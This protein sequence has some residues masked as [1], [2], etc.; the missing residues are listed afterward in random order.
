VV[1]VVEFGK[2]SRQRASRLT[3]ENVEQLLSRSEGKTKR[4]VEELLAS[5]AP[6]PTVK[7][8]IRKRPRA[9][10]STEASSATPKR[11]SGENALELLAALGADV[12]ERSGKLEPAT[13]RA[14]NY[15]FSA[16]QGFREKLERLGEVLGVHDPG[17]NMVEV[18][19]RAMEFTLQR[20]DPQRRLERR[21]EREARREPCP[22][23]V[24]AAADAASSARG[25]K[26]ERRDTSP[27]QRSRYI[28]I[29]AREHTL[30][31][32]SYRCE[33]RA[34]DGTR[35]RARTS[36]EVDHVQPFG[37]GGGSAEDN[38]RVLC[39][40]HNRL[41]AERAYGAEVTA[42]RIK[43]SRAASRWRSPPERVA[44][45]GC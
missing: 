18:F 19:E 11:T 41:F 34:P 29:A 23:E 8:S 35:C 45:P 1:R 25:P 28:P 7:P 22:G 43:E 38:L 5:L 6:K 15:C 31:R 39:R 17:R 30:E 9:R 36:L 4:E 26:R 40:G 33:Y 24:P 37:K 2:R 21:K 3:E 16:D 10:R 20:K 44:Q 14:F 13:E 27:R 42:R 32:A 12:P